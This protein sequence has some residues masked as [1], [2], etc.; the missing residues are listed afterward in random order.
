MVLLDCAIRDWVLLP[1]SLVVLMVNFLR[2]SL[3]SAM[4]S[5]PKSDPAELKTS[6]LLARAALLK[7]NGCY[8]TMESYSKK[9]AFFNKK[10]VGMFNNPP[11]KKD[12]L[13]AM[14]PDP[15][16][17]MGM[18]KGQLIFIVLQMGMAYWSNVMFSG[19]LVAKVPFPLTFKFKSMLQR[20]FDMPYLDVTY[21]SSVSWYF[22][23]LF[24]SSGMM[25][26]I[27]DISGSSTNVDLHSSNAM[28]MNPS[29]MM[30]GGGMGGPMGAP[31]PA[32]KYQQERDNLEL[33]THEFALL[34]VETSLLE[35]WNSETVKDYPKAPNLEIL[36]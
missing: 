1:V 11:E 30:P 36:I 7:T 32:K 35:R 19:F 34:D 18:V 12:P 3:M 24:G 26:L 20:G 31:D 4:K 22:F 6:Q 17:T 5:E 14:S 23:N 27:H 16:Q 28:M 33:L 13:Q 15:T 2:V 25:T 9:K 8:L 21:V 10:D 29:A